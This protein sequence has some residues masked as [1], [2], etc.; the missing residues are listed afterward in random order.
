M[1]RFVLYALILRFTD[2]DLN[3]HRYISNSNGRP[4]NFRS[5][6]VENFQQRGINSSSRKIQ[7]YFL[8]KALLPTH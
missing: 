6:R 4:E 8:R 5:E 2:F 3:I 1:V 7:L